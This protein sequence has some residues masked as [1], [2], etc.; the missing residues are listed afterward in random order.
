M[1]SCKRWTRQAPKQ[2]PPGRG[3]DVVYSF[4]VIAMSRNARGLARVSPLLSSESGSAMRTSLV[5]EMFFARRGS[6]NQKTRS[7]VAPGLKETSREYQRNLRA[8]SEKSNRM[9]LRGR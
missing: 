2:K 5:R 4:A 3:G 9:A 8:F 6:G 1:P 7:G